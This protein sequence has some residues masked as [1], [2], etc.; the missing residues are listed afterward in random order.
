V[1]LLLEAKDIVLNFGGLRALDGISI[2]IR[3][4]EILGM[5][6][7]NGSGKTT[8][9]NVLTKI[10]SPEEGWIKLRGERIDHL[11]THE[12]AGKGIA[13]TFQN[14]RIFKNISV[15]NNVIIGFH[16]LLKTNALNIF[17]RPFNFIQEETAAKTKAMGL[18]ETVGLELK[19]QELAKNLPY[20]EQRRLELARALAT[21]PTL[22]LLDEPTA[23]M[24]PK[25]SR[26]M[27]SLL[28][29][30]NKTGKTIFMIEHN[31]RTVMTV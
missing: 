20:G 5:I 26:G 14:L 23:G 22:L 4:R 28:K 17:F 11:S 27:I 16:R 15:L 18:L 12:I 2:T 9:I 1:A 29:E 21:E 8:F 31:M 19:A 10:Y 7:P 13:R 3:E 24:N 6:G 30:I 25:E